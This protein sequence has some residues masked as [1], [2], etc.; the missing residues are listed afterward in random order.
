[1]ELYLQL[2]LQESNND[3]IIPYNKYIVQKQGQNEDR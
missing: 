1:M 2:Y 3:F